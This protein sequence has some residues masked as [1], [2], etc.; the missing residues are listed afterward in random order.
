M[1]HDSTF[2]PVAS[3]AR[4]TT[5]VDRATLEAAAGS[6]FPPDAPAS[7]VALLAVGGYGRRQLFPHSDVDLLL[8][9]ATERA[10]FERKGDVSAFLQRLWDGGLRVSQSVRTPEE[11]LLV[12][13]HNA[14]LNISLLDRRYLA[15]DRALYDAL[16][17]RIPRF[18]HANRDA[19]IG[20]L[21]RLTRDR[22][23]KYADTF[24]HLEPNV[25]E[26]PGGLRDYQSICWLEQLRGAA[27]AEPA[28]ELRQAF[29][30]LARIRCRLHE[31][32]GRDQNALTFDEQDAM[33]EQ[34][35]RGGAAEW[36][37]E[38]YRHSRAV[39]RAATRELEAVEA[40]NSGLFAQ[41]RD[42]RSRLGNADIGVR[43]ERSH[44]RE[45]QLLETDPGLA[46]RCSNSRRATAFGRRSRP[47]GASNRNSAAWK[48][49]SAD[50]RRF[51]LL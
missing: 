42:W 50:R 40:Q 6:L 8:L 16:D 45:P 38:Y 24:Y 21:A 46:L 4:R 20:N 5:E 33:A 43:R 30:H 25:K 44:F 36:M 18:L 11:C 32:A 47:S 10:A 48:R 26:T 17:A 23:G 29:E 49:T 13:D 15:G 28:P 2:D 3:L 14:E 1:P 12:H 19:L 34:W 31:D 35:G 9:F 41:F 7:G 37:R 39:Y 22:H 27:S 51:G